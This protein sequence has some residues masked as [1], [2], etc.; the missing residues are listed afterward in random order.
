MASW[1]AR[2]DVE[3]QHLPHSFEAGNVLRSR[4]SERISVVGELS[5]FLLWAGLGLENGLEHF[6][7]DGI[8]WPSTVGVDG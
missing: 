7:D 5:A 1:D 3:K 8:I 6:N 4:I 2:D